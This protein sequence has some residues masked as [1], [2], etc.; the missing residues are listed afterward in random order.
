MVFVRPDPMRKLIVIPAYN[1]AESIGSLIRHLRAEGR[2]DI[3]VINDGS[4]DNT[5]EIVRQS[6][7][8]FVSLPLNLG[9]GGAVQ[10]GFR[11][12]FENR[13]DVVMQLDGDG[14]HDPSYIE[15]LIR[16]IL[17]DRADVVIGS[18]F[19]QKQGF[20]SSFHRRMGIRVLQWLNRILTGR[21]ITDCTS[22]FRAYNFKAVAFL[23]DHYSVDFPE[24]EAIISMLKRGF[25]IVE[26][27]VIM[28]SRE[29]GRSSIRGWKSIYYICKVIVSITIEYFRSSHE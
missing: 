12:A 21:H 25:R 9:I 16:P 29:H 19:I 4:S 6:G 22:G 15:D 1:E 24:P 20:Q 10:T 11:Y 8:L 3:L 5:E 14:Q 7:V 26:V 17:D 18:R 13:Y 23:A 28:R 2:S 27:P